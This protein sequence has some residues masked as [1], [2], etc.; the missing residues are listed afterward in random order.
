MASTDILDIAPS[1]V[2][3]SKAEEKEAM[4]KAMKL[5]GLIKDHK[6]DE[7]VQDET[8]M[9]K[10]MWSSTLEK[11]FK[12]LQTVK[13]TLVSFQPVGVEGNGSEKVAKVLV[14][15]E[16]EDLMAVIS[17]NTAGLI[18]RF[19]LKLMKEVQTKL[20]KPSYAKLDRF[21]EEHITLVAGKIATEAILS[22]PRD[23][24]IAGV[25]VLG[26]SGLTGSDRAIEPNELLKDLAW[27]LASNGIVVCR[28]NNFTT[29]NSSDV[30]DE[31]ITVE[32]KH[33]P[34][35]TAAIK[36]LRFKL[37]TIDP[38]TNIPIFFLGH[39]LGGM[40][41][42]MIAK[43]DPLIRG[44]LLLSTAG[45]ELYFSALREA[46]YPASQETRGSSVKQYD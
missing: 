1:P 4:A 8:E 16:K 41:A 37:S 5:L 3:L 44:L 25:V 45:G 35:A 15:F 24:P 39:G 32:K 33:L 10:L 13:G 27:G 2:Q 40:V 38:Q 9:V 34:Y 29:E 42:P 12:D 28:R 46:Q 31:S 19:R 23:K 30:S 18:T 7:A 20:K 17:I 26:G 14:K 36:A 11:L 43:A 6:F 21:V 22:V